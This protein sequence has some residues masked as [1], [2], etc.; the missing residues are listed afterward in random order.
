VQL[1]IIFLFQALLC[2]GFARG[3]TSFVYESNDY[4]PPKA[5]GKKTDSLAPRSYFAS[6]VGAGDNFSGLTRSLRRDSFNVKAWVN[7]AY[8][9]RSWQ[10]NLKMDYQHNY[11]DSS[12]KGVNKFSTNEFR[13][14]L[15]VGVYPGELNSDSS[16]LRLQLS[17]TPVIRSHQKVSNEF[18]LD[19]GGKVANLKGGG[20]IL[21][22]Y[23]FI[24]RPNLS[25]YSYGISFFASLVN[26]SES[27]VISG[28]DYQGGYSRAK[29]NGNDKSENFNIGLVTRFLGPDVSS[30]LYL[31]L[32]YTNYYWNHQRIYSAGIFYLIPAISKIRRRKAKTVGS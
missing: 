32:N 21:F 1:R 13:P 26:F 31:F 22:Q 14:K 20:S 28:I 25:S 27:R 3:Q 8:Y 6:L 9:I 29:W 19:Y 4:V 30:T 10:F 17:W 18:E 24:D 2:I 7:T 5:F 15:Q 23:Y 12:G 16:N 11:I